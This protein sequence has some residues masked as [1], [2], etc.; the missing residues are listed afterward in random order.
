MVSINSRSFHSLLVA[1]KTVFMKSNDNGMN[2]Y[3]K[4]DSSFS[5]VSLPDEQE[6]HDD[7]SEM[8]DCSSSSSS[9]TSSDN[10]VST[11]QPFEISKI[12]E[13][14]EISMDTSSSHH[15]VTLESND[16]CME[17]TPLIM[18]AAASSCPQSI[19]R[20]GHNNKR[21]KSSLNDAKLQKDGR[22]TLTE[23]N[24][25]L[26][27]MSIHGHRWC[28]VA[29]YVPTRSATQIRSHAQKHFESKLCKRN[30]NSRRSRNKNV[31][32]KKAVQNHRKSSTIS[33][34]LASQA[35]GKKYPDI[36]LNS[37]KENRTD[38]ISPKL[39]KLISNRCKEDMVQE[40]QQYRK[41]HC[42]QQKQDELDMVKCN[43]HLDVIQ[44]PEQ[45]QMECCP[46]QQDL[47]QSD[48]VKFNNSNNKHSIQ[49]MTEFSSD[50]SCCRSISHLEL[51]NNNNNNDHHQNDT[52]DISDHVKVAS[53]LILL[54]QSD[55]AHE[56]NASSAIV[57]NENTTEA[58]LHKEVQMTLI[59]SKER[60]LNLCQKYYNKI[61]MTK[62]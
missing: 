37:S 59:D 39:K 25:F 12:G 3:H 55:N 47:Q 44:E 38:L 19:H 6:D 24:L 17:Y 49:S 40:Q 21:K 61:Q 54:S 29:K 35:E 58:L 13:I 14:D 5:I 23:H 1:N 36:S 50:G 8:N 27:G 15:D 22:W 57:N 31:K 60:Y 9:I 62:V 51:I 16:D 52:N 7:T 48:L 32:N 34:K 20:R 30:P 11:I 33:S 28:R 53:A 46:Q 45:Y 26:L 41:E 43:K 2:K 18:A 42:Q 56:V 10:E 4:N